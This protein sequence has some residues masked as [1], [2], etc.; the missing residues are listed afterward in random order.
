MDKWLRIDDIKR[1]CTEN[2]S[3]VRISFILST[4]TVKNFVLWYEF[5]KKYNAFL[6]DDRCDAA[7]TVLLHHAMTGGYERISSKYPI[8][9]KLFY[10]LKYQ[11]IP[12]LVNCNSKV[13][14]INL[15]MPTTSVIYEGPLVVTG[16]SRGVDSFATYV[17]YFKECELDKYRVNAFTYF[18]VGAHHGYD[19][20]L[21]HGEETNHELYL[22]QL[23][24]TK[25]FC[26]KN[27]LELITVTS[28]IDQITNMRNLWSDKGFGQTHAWRNCS[29]VMLLQKIICRYYYSSA[30]TLS[31]FKLDMND[32]TAYYEQYL[33]PY[34]S[35]GSTEFYESNQDWSRLDKVK[36]IAKYEEC[37]DYLQVC[38]M[39]SGNCG[40]CTKCKRTLLELDSLGEDVL[41]SFGK[42]FDLDDYKQNYRKQWFSQLLIDKEK[43]HGEGPFYDEVFVNAYFHHP[44]ILGDI[45]PVKNPNIHKV[46]AK[47]KINIRFLPSLRSEILGIALPGDTFTYLGEGGILVGIQYNETKKAYLKRAFVDLM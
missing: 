42:S 36:K 1:T 21:G 12:Q 31:T 44:E 27:N 14:R 20:K 19:S 40:H 43:Q 11:V 28:N 46:V 9:E 29:V 47:D 24:K 38:L 3:K 33:L 39:K 6:T 23:K 26:D 35:T 34:L 16:M 25:E 2:T 15:D 13:S 10:N 41:N 32:D 45:L 30:H 4:D 22:N 17:E 37:Q 18:E 7:I 8:S 5:D